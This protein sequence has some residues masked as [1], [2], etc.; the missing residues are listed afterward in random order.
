M[1][2]RNNLWLFR[3]ERATA[4]MEFAL[5][6]PV[7]ILLIAG[8]VEFG[9]IFQ[10]YN[11]VNRLASQ[12]AIAWA[13]CDDKSGACSSSGELLNY[14]PAI[15]VTN[16][17]PQL[18]NFSSQGQLRMFQISMSAAAPVITYVYPTTAVLSTAEIA[19]AQTLCPQPV[20]TSTCTGQTGV[21]VTATYNYTPSYFTTLM[22]PILQGRLTPTYTVA[23]LKS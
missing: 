19:A 7:L 20:S 9:N 5:I 14:T 1:L 16:I 23:Q 8:V 17:F 21:I 12:Y 6:A 10:V 15:A 13:D 3:C 4:A 18:R 11:A 2:L 22:T